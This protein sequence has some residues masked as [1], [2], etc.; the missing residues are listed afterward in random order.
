MRCHKL[1]A[2]AEHRHHDVGPELS[3]LSLYPDR[4]VALVGDP[5]E[6]QVTGGLDPA[7]FRADLPAPTPA[8]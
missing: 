6:L 3:F 1:R 4:M 5:V 7:D 8:S 2:F